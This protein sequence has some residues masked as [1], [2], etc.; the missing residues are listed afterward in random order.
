MLLSMLPIIIYSYNYNKKYYYL[1]SSIE[2]HNL[3]S[4]NS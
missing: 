3:I 1:L 2:P 4:F